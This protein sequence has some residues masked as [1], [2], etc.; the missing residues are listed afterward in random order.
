MKKLRAENIVRFLGVC[1]KDSQTMLV[2]EYM[3]GGDLFNRLSVS[4]T[5]DELSWRALYVAYF[6]HPTYRFILVHSQTCLLNSASKSRSRSK[7]HLH[8]SSLCLCALFLRN[9][10]CT[11]DCNSLRLPAEGLQPFF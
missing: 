6:S 5:G 8:R 4:E 1:N 11:A 9:G 10:S 7:R 3:A 2:T